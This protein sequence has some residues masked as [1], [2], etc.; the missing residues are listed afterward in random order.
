MLKIIKLPVSTPESKWVVTFSPLNKRSKYN[1]RL[2]GGVHNIETSIYS[3]YI[4]V[5][6]LF[7]HSSFYF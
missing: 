2:G 3:K 1:N 7:E 6:V 5:L 4:E